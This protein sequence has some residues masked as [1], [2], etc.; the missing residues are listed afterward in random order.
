MRS[1]DIYIKPIFTHIFSLLKRTNSLQRPNKR[2]IVFCAPADDFVNERDKKHGSLWHVKTLPSL[3]LTSHVCSPSCEKLPHGIKRALC[4]YLGVLCL[5]VKVTHFLVIWYNN[6]K[7]AFSFTWKERD[8]G[9]GIERL[10][11]CVRVCG[12]GRGVWG[13][14]ELHAG[15]N[16]RENRQQCCYLPTQIT[17]ISPHPVI[18]VHWYKEQLKTIWSL[19]AAGSQFIWYLMKTIT[20]MVWNLSWKKLFYCQIH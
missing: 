3:F 2:S 17:L 11:V 16:L 19:I 10:C 8:E 14:V 7:T 9:G 5:S 1:G 15:K 4:R 20:D 12:G 18:K 13:T 6:R